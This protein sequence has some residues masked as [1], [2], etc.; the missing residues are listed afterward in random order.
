MEGKTVKRALI[1]MLWLL[2][3]FVNYGTTLGYF[4]HR[5]PYD[6]NVQISILFAI[7]GPFFYSRLR[8]LGYGIS[9]AVETVQH[10]GTMELLA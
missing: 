8:A 3:S 4:S 1:V 5:F 9:L 7:G 10:R 2:C 6:D